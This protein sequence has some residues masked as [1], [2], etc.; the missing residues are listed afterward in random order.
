MEKNTGGFFASASRESVI[1]FEK[2]YFDEVSRL[3]STVHKLAEEHRIESSS[4][5]Q[6][7]PGQIKKLADLRAAGIVTAEEFEAKKK[8]LLDRL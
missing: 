4:T 2:K 7:I 8:Q 3:A 1:Q 6:D 5:G